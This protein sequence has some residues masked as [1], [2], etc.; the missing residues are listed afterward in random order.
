VTAVEV[1]NVRLPSVAAVV[2]AV[3][4]PW[5]PKVAALVEAGVPKESDPDI[6]ELV[7]GVANVK[8]V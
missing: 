4:N 2:T 8:P 3:C 5:K 6:P 1:P 7:V